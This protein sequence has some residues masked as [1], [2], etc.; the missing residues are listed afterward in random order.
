MLR[1][2]LIGTAAGAAG[3]CALN[4]VTYLDMTLRGRPSSDVP[5][6]T[7]G[8]IAAKVGVD[9]DSHNPQ[10]TKSER[11]QEIKARQSGLGALMGFGVGI[12]LGA[13]YGLL[14]PFM[15]DTPLALTSLGLGAAAMAAG[16]LPAI[17]TDS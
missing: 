16:D 8:K 12:K 4:V 10:Q 15:S 2:I 7:A 11:E 6:Q 3:T 14:R 9:L 13:L 5:A 1:S 17:A